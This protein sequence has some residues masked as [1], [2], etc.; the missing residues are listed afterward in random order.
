MQETKKQN[1]LKGAAILAAASILVKIGSA[2]YK[3]PLVNILG[4]VGYGCF[5]TTYNIYALLLTISSMG[6]PIALSRMVS[7][8]YAKKDTNLVKRYFSVAMPVFTAIGV[9]VTLVMYFF[10]DSFA[11]FM[12]NSSAAPGIRVL[13]PA[14]FFSCIISIYRGYMQGFE[15]MTPT[16]V[17]QVVEVVC[18]TALGIVI[19]KWL[20]DRYYDFSLVSAGAIMGV[21]IAAG[22]CIPLLIWYKRRNDRAISLP[23]RAVELSGAGTGLPGR[24]RIA[25]QLLK[26]S[27]PITIGTSFL[28]IMTVIDQSVVL[29][30][31]QNSLHFTELESSGFFGTYSLCLNIYNLPSALI[32]PISIS[33]VPAIAAALARKNRSEAGGT[34]Q[35]AVKLVNLLAMPACAGIIVLS[36]PI[37]VTLYNDSEQLTSTIM[38]ILGAAS[39]FVCLQLITAAIL[40]ANG[41]ERIAMITVPIGGVIQIALDYVLVGTPGVGIVGS[42]IGTLI[43]FIVISMLNIVFIQI[44]VKDKPKFLGVF[45]K[46]LLCAAIMAAAAFLSYELLHRLGSGIIGA[47]RMAVAAFLVLA[48]IIAVIVYAVLIIIT[49][50]ITKEDLALVPKAEKLAK[51][52]RIR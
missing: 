44:K 29:G 5:Q 7:S 10:A 30:R 28:S 12:N 52:L 9:V 26:V 47:G 41:F 42:P 14:V 50:T 8:A 18:K 49:R 34:M 6:I 21:T 46:P 33:I 1:Y 19:A 3:I 51:L 39:F 24:G 20:S 36:R 31:L 48:I 43:C 15:N 40:Q 17:T 4:K 38:M 13:A 11:G 45:I 16:A 22:L 27:I 2:I 25:A 23:D 37:L 35:S 32:A